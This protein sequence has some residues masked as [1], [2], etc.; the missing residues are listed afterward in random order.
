VSVHYD[1]E[2][3]MEQEVREGIAHERGRGQVRAE[4]R[5]A[6]LYFW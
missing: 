4:S 2:T 3:G 5:I 1:H 6:F